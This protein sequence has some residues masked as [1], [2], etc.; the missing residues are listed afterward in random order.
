MTAALRPQFTLSDDELHAAAARV[1]VQ[2]FPAVL[3]TRRRHA[4]I[5]GQQAAWDW[6]TVALARRGLVVDGAVDTDL[7]ALLQA[8]QRPQRAL[9]MRLV[10]PE[11]TCRVCLGRTGFTGVLARRLGDHVLLRDI[12]RAAELGD[13]TAVLLG[14]LP[15]S[16]AAPIQ[17]IGAPTDAMA[18]AL[19][20]S[21][22]A[23]VMADRVRALGVDSRSAMVLGIAL[24]S[25]EAFAEIVYHAMVAGQ[26]RVTRTSA[27]V[28]VFYTKRGRII[29]T[30]SA[31]PTGQ[32]WTTL[33]AGSAHAIS[34]AVDR[35][36]ELSGERWGDC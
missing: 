36:V 26:D 32:L 16:A 17:A 24:A 9:A 23:A 19:S 22:D 31:S 7:A 6:A 12:G 3:A 4:T 8:L 10:T 11:G 28:G 27:A 1:G 35:L 25:R 34:Q 5:S 18:D 30:P 33:K 13:A 15:P 29:A 21:H 14:E 20:G 2:S